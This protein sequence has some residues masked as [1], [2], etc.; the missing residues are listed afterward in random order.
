MSEKQEEIARLDS[1]TIP[2][3]SDGQNVSK[4]RSS[5]K[6]ITLVRCVY[7][8]LVLIYSIIW[9]HGTNN[10]ELTLGSRMLLGC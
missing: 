7:A 8:V 3:P 2:I 5:L 1:Q 4:I 6:S 10:L 9:L